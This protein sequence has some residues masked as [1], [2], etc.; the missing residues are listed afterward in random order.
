[1]N[2]PANV[3]LQRTQIPMFDISRAAHRLESD[4]TYPPDEAMLFFK[5]EDEHI[6]V[7]KG[8]AT[9]PPP[10]PYTSVPISKC[11]DPQSRKTEVESAIVTLLLRAQEMTQR[12][13]AGPSH[14]Q[15]TLEL[16]GMNATANQNVAVSSAR[17]GQDASTTNPSGA[18]PT[19]ASP[20]VASPA[21]A[22]SVV[23]NRTVTDPATRHPLR[24]RLLPDNTYVTRHGWVHRA[25]GLIIRPSGAMERTDG[26]LVQANGDV[27]YP[28][29]TL[30]E[31]TGT[32]WRPDGY[33]VT[34]SGRVIGPDFMTE[35]QRSADWK[36]KEAHATRRLTTWLS[37]LVN[38]LVMDGLAIAGLMGYGPLAVSNG[39]TVS[40]TPGASGSNSTGSVDSTACE[41][42]RFMRW[43]CIGTLLSLPMVG[44]A[45][46]STALKENHN[47]KVMRENQRYRVMANQLQWY[48]LSPNAAYTPLWT[49][50]LP[51]PYPNPRASLEA[52]RDDPRAPYASM[53][54][55]R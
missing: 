43:A 19:V 54:N 53:R 17:R 3:G 14:F 51:V 2:N 32:V 22:Q 16:T 34:P 47:R 44:I 37:L 48:N 39:C 18:S 38:H 12:S 46:L 20:A 25:D 13:E 45:L 29:G 52:Q 27:L 49:N 15:H 1:M 4:P 26:A 28:D 55:P 35:S 10:G 7:S 31:N 23:A 42:E 40:C 33:G 8:T 41:H 50:P 30:L 9:N 5:L 21:T 6:V 11:T 36:Q 24:R